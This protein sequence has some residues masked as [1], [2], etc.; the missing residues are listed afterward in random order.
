MSNQL[1]IEL[2]SE[3]HVILPDT[4]F[5]INVND[6]IASG[7]IN[8]GYTAT[9]D[10]WFVGAGYEWV[11][12]K[13]DSVHITSGLYG[14]SGQYNSPILLLKGQVVTASAAWGSGDPK[15]ATYKVYGLK[16]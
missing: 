3:S 10:S 11:Q 15:N 9:K 5:G 12:F 7:K 8:N 1:R 16:Y 4:V 13:V 14:A 2:D 6:V